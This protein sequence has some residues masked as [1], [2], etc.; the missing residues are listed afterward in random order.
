MTSRKRRESLSM[1]TRMPL[2]WPTQMMRPH[3]PKTATAVAGGGGAAGAAPALAFALLGSP[4][5]ATPGNTWYRAALKS[6]NTGSPAAKL[7]THAL[8]S[9]SSMLTFRTRKV[10]KSRGRFSL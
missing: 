8:A 3:F 1:A 6:T 9:L 7:T 4:S 2:G 5:R 10:V